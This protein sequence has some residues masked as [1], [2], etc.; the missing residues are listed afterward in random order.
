ME[1][2]RKSVN[3]EGKCERRSP[4]FEV[5]QKRE[6]EEGFRFWI[7]AQ[8]MP[9]PPPPHENS[10]NVHEQCERSGL[11]KND[12]VQSAKL[13]QKGIFHFG[14]PRDECVPPKERRKV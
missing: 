14:L 10:V 6:E 9:G 2:R 12:E 7:G 1:E 11:S 3:G 8:Q 13:T 5:G 4:K